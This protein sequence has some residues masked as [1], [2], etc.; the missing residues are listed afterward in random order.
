[1]D[2]RCI[3]DSSAFLVVV[4]W[5]MVEVLVVVRCFWMSFGGFGGRGF[6]DDILVVDVSVTFVVTDAFVAVQVLWI[7]A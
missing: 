7:L 1:M 4:Q 2:G 6:G 3:S 5:L